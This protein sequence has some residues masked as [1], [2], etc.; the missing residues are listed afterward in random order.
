MLDADVLAPGD[1]FAGAKVLTILPYTWN[2]DFFRRRVR[3]TCQ[4]VAIG[5]AKGS[6]VVTIAPRIM[7]ADQGET[8]SLLDYQRGD[9]F[10][11]NGIGAHVWR[12]IAAGRSLTSICSSIAAEYEVGETVVQSDVAALLV[13]LERKSLVVLR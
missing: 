10:A 4:S 13:E 5:I 7:L 2:M 3:W 8:A 6:L 9:Y 1:A 11:L 12:E